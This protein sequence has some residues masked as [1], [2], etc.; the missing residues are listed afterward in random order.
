MINT[1]QITSQFETFHMFTANFGPALLPQTVLSQ[2]DIASGS[3]SPC[4][5]HN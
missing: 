2:Q 4:L 5:Y 1:L 3:G